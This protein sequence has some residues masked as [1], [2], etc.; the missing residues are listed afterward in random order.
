MLNYEAR[1][2]YHNN[3]ISSNSQAG[4]RNMATHCYGQLVRVLQKLRFTSFQS[5]YDCLSVYGHN[6]SL[7]FH[8]RCLFQLSLLTLFYNNV[9]I[10]SILHNTVPYGDIKI[11]HSNIKMLC[12]LK[13]LHSASVMLFA[14]QPGN[15]V[16]NHFHFLLPHN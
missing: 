13:K 1:L 5:V 12:F 6:V 14:S 11:Y 8:N 10:L 4:Q 15:Q 2:C 3:D 7:H 9:C 16:T